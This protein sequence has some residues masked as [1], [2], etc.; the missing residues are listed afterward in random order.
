[1]GKGKLVVFEGI[2]GS[3]KSTQAKLLRDRL[4]EIGSPAVR[5]SELENGSPLGQILGPIIRQRLDPLEEALL[6]A[7]AR[8]SLTSQIIKPFLEH[9]SIV[10]CDR[11][12]A[13]GISYSVFGRG[14]DRKFVESLLPSLVPDLV[15]YLYISP[16]VA[17]KRVNQRLPDYLA[18]LYRLSEVSIGFENQF[19]Q[20]AFTGEKWIKIEGT[21]D[22]NEIHEKVWD[23]VQSLF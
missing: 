20:T 5:C 15:V 3:G 8:H 11:Y 4:R 7:A 1:M 23:S 6:F 12:K 9:G 16:A 18:D 13:S 14:L 21:L 19:K 2:D 17:S 10:I 22:Q